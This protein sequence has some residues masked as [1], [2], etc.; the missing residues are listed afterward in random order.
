[1]G[2]KHLKLHKD[3]YFSANT[4][5][6]I[7]ILPINYRSKQIFTNFDRTNSEFYPARAVL[8]N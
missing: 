5:H 6:F 7:K 1:M 4:Q 3:N 8:Y 2:I